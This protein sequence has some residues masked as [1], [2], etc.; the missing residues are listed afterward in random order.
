MGQEHSDVSFTD[1]STLSADWSFPSLSV[2]VESFYSC[3]V[4]FLVCFKNSFHGKQ[5]FSP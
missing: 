1:E 5:L 2:F 4:I 3:S